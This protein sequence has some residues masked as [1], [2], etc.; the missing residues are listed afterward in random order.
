[1][2]G[3]SAVS[4]PISAQPARRQPSA[5][6]ATTAAATCLVELPG[7]V[8][9]EEEQRLGALDDEV[10]GA[11]RDEVDADAV[12]TPGFDRELELGADAIVGGDEQRVGIA[13]C[14]EVEEAAESAEFGI[15]T[16]PRG[17]AREGSDR[18]HQRIAGLDRHAGIGIS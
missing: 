12:V 2:P 13:G 16:G 6:D 9:I 3:I 11:H 4:P 8:I 5:I 18:L 7:R 15:R 1:M 14:L 17:R 10:V